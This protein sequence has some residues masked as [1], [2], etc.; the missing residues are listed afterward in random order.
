MPN[1]VK[2]NALA[3]S[4]K[5]FPIV[6]IGASAGGLAAFETFFLNLPENTPLAMAFVLVQHLSP[7]HKSLLPEILQ[8][9]TQMKVYEV[10]DGMIV[11]PRC[12]YVIPPNYDMALQQG[13]LKLLQRVKEAEHHLPIDFLFESLATDLH[14]HA[15]AIVLSGAGSDGCQGLRAIKSGCGMVMAQSPE[16]LDFDSMPRMAIETGLVDYVLPVEQLPSKLIDYVNHAYGKLSPLAD[17]YQ[18][19]Y[20]EVVMQKIFLLLQNQTGHDFSQYKLST[21]KRRI[22][23]RLSVHQIAELNDY[24]KFLQKTPNEIDALFMDILIGVT[25]FFRDPE[26]FDSLTEHI[27]TKLLFHN[28]SERVVRVWIP[29]CSTGEEP[30]SIAILLVEAMEQ[31]GVNC[32]VQIFATDINPQAIATARVGCYPASIMGD[33]SPERLAKFFS[34]EADGVTYRIDRNIRDK[35]VFSEHDLLK[36]PPF[37]KLDLISCRNLLIYMDASLQKRI[38]PLFHY[39]LKTDGLLFLGISEGIGEHDNLFNILDRKNKLYQ[40]KDSLYSRY[41]TATS[42]YFP[43]TTA[44]SASLRPVVAAAAPIKLPLRALTEQV[45]IQHANCCAALVN[46]LGDI[47]YLHGR[48]G[49]YLEPAVG[50]VGV[51][52]ILK[53]SR[54]GLGNRLGVA[55][56]KVVLSGQKFRDDGLLVKTNGHTSLV[57]LSVYPVFSKLAYLAESPLYVVVLELAQDSH[58]Q[59]TPSSVAELSLPSETSTEEHQQTIADLRH[60]VFLKDEY[61]CIVREELETSNEELKSTNEEM[62]SVNEE[63]QSTNEEL[64]TSKEELQS[65]NEELNTVNVELQA[66]VEIASQVIS[67]MNNLLDGSG[68]ATLFVDTQLRILRFTPL[69]TQIIN[70][71]QLDI[72]R[73]LN[74]IAINFIGYQDLM[75]DINSILNDLIPIKKRVQAMDEK[76]Y[77]LCLRPYRTI[78]NMISGVV[79]TFVD[80][81]DTVRIEEDLEKANHLL[82]LAVVVRDAHDAIT[83]QD[84][85]GHIIA[86]N[87]GAERIYGWSEEQALQLNVAARIPAALVPKELEKVQALSHAKVFEPYPTQRLHKNGQ[88]LSVWIT[89]TALINEVG[90]VYAVATTERLSEE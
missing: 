42:N 72:H 38:I 49:L 48:T 39:S 1:K 87:P 8:R 22:E 37:S 41:Q 30:Y 12:V 25:H 58:N 80:I 26:T 73:P 2:T 56:H 83:V 23:R 10:E 24:V 88:L 59:V 70:L 64:E 5:Q 54:L 47:Y 21:I 67:D 71:I 13:R 27:K 52:N 85:E 53:M 68:I 63:L 15:I 66:K 46:G 57:N 75:V 62:Q 14:E 32:A 45:L 51:N 11:E 60:E 19:Q 17:S 84:L 31:L 61:L 29:G 4:T 89:A 86:W 36:D 43:S 77:S 76:W 33:V 34:L 55:L 90:Q 16:G 6:G 79:L 44:I 74:H 69:I 40:R 7:T 3:S 35:V 65:V 82:R 9:H 50:E 78:N 81:S 28:S 20:Q 18:N